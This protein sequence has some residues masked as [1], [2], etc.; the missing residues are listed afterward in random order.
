MYSLLKN[1]KNIFSWELKKNCFRL[2]NKNGLKN[3]IDLINIEL[4]FFFIFLCLW[5]NLEGVFCKVA[6]LKEIPMTQKSAKI[7]AGRHVC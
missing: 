2:E 4:L 3:C 6:S 7:L 5:A 1:V